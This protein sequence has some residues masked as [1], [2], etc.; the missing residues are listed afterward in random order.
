MRVCG[1]SMSKTLGPSGLDREATFDARRA[2]VGA[3][4]FGKHRLSGDTDGRKA[5]TPSPFARVLEVHGHACGADDFGRPVAGH[6]AAAR[7]NRRLARTAS[8]RDGHE[9]PRRK[10]SEALRRS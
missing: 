2:H 8:Y 5:R 3:L 10:T 4:S 1:E 6:G 7:R 9:L